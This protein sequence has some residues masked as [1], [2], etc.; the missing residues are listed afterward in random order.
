MNN[1]KDIDDLMD[2]FTESSDK[3]LSSI[4]GFPLL[5]CR[6]MQF[7]VSIKGNPD[8]LTLKQTNA[9]VIDDLTTYSKELKESGCVSY[10][11]IDSYIENIKGV[12]DESNN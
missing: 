2:K 4:I 9:L 10:M 12:S 1:E 11:F 8:K 6:L 5:A 7:S 3:M